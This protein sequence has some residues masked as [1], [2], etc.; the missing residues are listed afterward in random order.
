MSIIRKRA[1]DKFRNVTDGYLDYV[2][3][4]FGLQLPKEDEEVLRK[5]VHR[6]RQVLA[7]IL[8]SVGDTAIDLPRCSM[9]YSILEVVLRDLKE[10]PGCAA[11]LLTDP[12]NIF[13]PLRLSDGRV[14]C[15]ECQSAI[16]VGYLKQ[17]I[18]VGEK[19]PSTLLIENREFPITE[20]LVSRA[21]REC[22]GGING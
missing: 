3:F 18:Q 22:D 19:L 6:A 20:A 15:V 9:C 5:E 14:I 1:L 13:S 11:L 4:A 7:Q 12:K 21:R 8:R 2:N 16:L 10:V 17:V